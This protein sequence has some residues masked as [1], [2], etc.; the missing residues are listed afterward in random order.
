M[1]EHSLLVY[2]ISPVH[3]ECFYWKRVQSLGVEVKL[4]MQHADTRNVVLYAGSR[5]DG[6]VGDVIADCWYG[7]EEKLQLT[8]VAKVHKHL[9]LP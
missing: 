4:C 8:V 6:Q 2:D 9:C 3:E 1:L 7:W 5:K